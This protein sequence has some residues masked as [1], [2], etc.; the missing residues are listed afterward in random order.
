M[1]NELANS[2]NLFGSAGPRKDFS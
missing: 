2:L 1:K